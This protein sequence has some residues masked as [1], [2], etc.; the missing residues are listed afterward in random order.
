MNSI[1]RANDLTTQSLT[2]SQARRIALAAQGFGQRKHDGVSNWRRV[3]SAIDR[4]G[5]LQMDSISVTVRSHYLPAFSRVGPYDMDRL[6]EKSF[7]PRKREL[8]EYWA[9]EASLLPME[10]HPLLRWRMRRA[11]RFEGIWKG[12]AELCTERPEYVESVFNQIRE[13]GPLSSREFNAGG[14]SGGMWNW[15]EGK[16]ALEYLFWTGQITAHSRQGF[17]R[18]YDLTERVIP[19]SVLA[20][21]TPAEEDAM[22]ELL[23]ISARAL[24]IA[25][26]ADLR[27]YFR[28]PASDAKRR[29]AELVEMG[30]LEPVSVQGWSQTAYLTPD[31]KLPRWIRG[32][33]LLTP[34]DP[35]VWERNRTERLFGF[36]Y[37]IEIYTP[38]HKRQ[39][40]YYVLPFLHDDKLVARVDLKADRSSSILRVIGAFGETETDVPSVAHELHKELERYARWLGL[41]R[42]VISDNGDLA[43][44]LIAEAGRSS[45]QG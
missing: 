40:G 2:L 27:D 19:E 41:N 7:H 38:A 18:Y 5:L 43:L 21:P 11:E 29:V 26:E 36:K 6:N 42:I 16:T 39:Y 35:L 32:A 22:R 13:R 31:A 30:D 34:F 1:P 33:T 9:H 25:T 8:F 10:M 14:K 15:H 45:V 4:M 20:L 37:R 17:E 24:G 28:L 3:R 44:P 23:R 12:I